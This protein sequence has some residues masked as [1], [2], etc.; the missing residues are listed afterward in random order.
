MAHVAAKAVQE[1]QND[2]EDGLVI[3][4][5]VQMGNPPD[6]PMLVPA[7]TRVASEPSACPPR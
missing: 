2:N 7:I 5:N 4:H 1:A 3:D 6:A